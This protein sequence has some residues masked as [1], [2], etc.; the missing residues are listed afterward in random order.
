MKH[1]TWL[2]IAMFIYGVATAHFGAAILSLIAGVF[3]RVGVRCLD[4]RDRVWEASSARAKSPL[5]TEQLLDNHECE[6][7][8]SDLRR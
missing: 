3:Y 8:W 2:F 4:K 1:F 5:P 6:C 7:L